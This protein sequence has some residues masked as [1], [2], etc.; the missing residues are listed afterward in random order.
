MIF[1]SI[2]VEIE[3]FHF[4]IISMIFKLTLLLLRIIEI[5]RL[6]NDLLK[7]KFVMMNDE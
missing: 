7:K 3:D 4:Y 6:K 2:P 1:R 5:S